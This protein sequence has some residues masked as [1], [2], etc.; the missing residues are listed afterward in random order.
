MVNA[1]H[2]PDGQQPAGNIVGP[3]IM[4]NVSDMLLSTEVLEYM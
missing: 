1:L 3:D 4:E 2:L